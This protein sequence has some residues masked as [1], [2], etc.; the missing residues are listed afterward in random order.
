M[1]AKTA[2]TGLLLSLALTAAAS[3]QSASREILISHGSFPSMAVTGDGNFVVAWQQEPLTSSQTDVFVQLFNGSGRPASP[4][5]T[6]SD[7]FGDQLYPRVA[8]DAHG[9]FV[10]VWQGG[11]QVRAPGFPGGDGQG[12]GIF[13]QRFDRSGRRVGLTRIVNRQLGGLQL[14]PD[15]AMSPEGSFIIAWEDYPAPGLAS[16]VQ[17]QVFS[18]SGLRKGTELT[19]GIQNPSLS[20]KLPAVTAEPEGFA[21]GWTEFMDCQ[22]RGAKLVPVVA[23][24]N[25]SGKPLAPSFRLGDGSCEGFGLFL[26]GLSAGDSGSVALLAGFARHSV[27]LFTP[28]GEPAGPR[29]IVGERERCTGI[30][31][32]TVLSVAMDNSGRFAVVWALALDV[33]SSSE[34]DRYPP[35]YQLLARFFDPQGEPLGETFQVTGALSRFEPAVAAAL[36]DDGSLVVVW[37]RD[38]AT[39][40]K[41]GMFLRRFQID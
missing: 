26:R 1:R 28:S 12:T 5:L 36:S 18:P 29:R 7:A 11:S 27:Q 37:D 2:L 6:A 21:V 41:S 22:E 14:S 10:V 19:M 39:P 13:L 23:H 40:E 32:E 16:G 35:R 33:P 34:G 3:A 25:S 9:N 31:C 4:V 8:A 15:V 20:T 30:V 24:V 38:A 17:A